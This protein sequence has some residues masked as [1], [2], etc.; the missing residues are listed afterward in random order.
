MKDWKTHRD[1]VLKAI[2]LTLAEYNDKEWDDEVVDTLLDHI[3]YAHEVEE[4]ED[5]GP[6]T[7]E[8]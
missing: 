6:E 1:L 5:D 3:R 8:F 7:K 2:L 4:M